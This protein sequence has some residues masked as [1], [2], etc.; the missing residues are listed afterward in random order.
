MHF[1][2]LG[3]SH[4]KTPIEIREK[5]YFSEFKK[6][7]AIGLLSE[8]GIDN[9]IIL[10]TCNRCEIYVSCE[11]SDIDIN[12]LRN[13]FLEFFNLENL[14][15]YIFV[16]KDNDAIRHLYKVCAGMDS[17]VL[18]EDQILGQVKDALEN[19]V[20]LGASNK[21]LNKIFREAITTA[22][23]IKSK[24]KISEN[25]ISVSYIAVKKLCETVDE[26]TNKTVIVVGTG[27]MGILAINHLIELGV[28]NILCCNRSYDKLKYLTDKY[29]F[30][31]C[32]DYDDRYKL[33]PQADI[34]ITS[35]SSPHLIIKSQFIQKRDKHLYA[36][37]L[38]LPRDIESSIRQIPDI[39]LFDIDDL[40]EVSQ[41]NK[42]K[43]ED[44]SSK[45]V[46]N[47][48]KSIQE[49]EKWLKTEKS[50]KIIASLNKRCDIIY[51]DT[52]SYINRKID[53]NV[54]EK[55]II[56]KM[57]SSA[58]RR[59]IKLPI[60]NLK[61]SDNYSKQQEYIKVLNDLF[62]FEEK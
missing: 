10:S 2:V 34:L 60:E 17:I 4:N 58:L 46:E 7:E 19:S 28:K 14:N 26:I 53:L 48:D 21:Y 23:E 29:P 40:N 47:I 3:I 12:L 51:N 35:T 16:K 38:S 6:I 1:F 5:A 44:L 49:L 25:P 24:L 8:I 18:G 9:L 59:M 22:K 57:L 39:T 30:L 52:M 32:F 55:K 36:I 37:D 20:Q 15:D 61:N 43:R 56:E 42:K 50:D 41:S 33:I 11:E 13:F 62:N 45:A 54:R 27:K 31:K